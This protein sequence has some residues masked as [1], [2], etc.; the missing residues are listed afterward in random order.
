MA[1][2]EASFVYAHKA[3]AT[4][5]AEN[6]FV[7][8]KPIDGFSTRTTI[9]TFAACGRN[10]HYGQ[11]VEYLLDEPGIVPPA[12]TEVEAHWQLL[13]SGCQARVTL[14]WLPSVRD[15]DYTAMFWGNLLPQSED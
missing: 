11:M 8:I 5:T 2:L 10:D 15:G 7:A 14:S 9:A 4:I 13:L 1:A 6:A 12:S 3:I